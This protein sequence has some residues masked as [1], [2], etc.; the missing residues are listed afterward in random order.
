MIG[1]SA[2][3]MNATKAI[4]ETLLD[5]GD[6]VVCIV[7]HRSP[8]HSPLAQVLQYCTAMPVR[9][10]ST[11]PWD[12]PPGSVIVAPAGYHLL[13]GPNRRLADDPRTPV[14][15]YENAPGVRAHLAL[16]APVA[17]SR[18]SIDVTLTSAAALPNPLTAVLLSC[19][20]DDG[21][22]GCADV[23]AAGGRVVLQDPAT[24][25]AA[26]AVNAARRLVEPDHV[27]DPRGIGTWLSRM[28][29]R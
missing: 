21:A 17:Y 22:R 14:A 8:D 5:I 11:S 12:C 10:P 18:P 25:E 13:L 23:Q 24:C 26:M 19:A 15:L 27:A 1:G 9:E 29:T 3:G 6:A 2:G 28:L 7:L 4:F 20:N 16:D